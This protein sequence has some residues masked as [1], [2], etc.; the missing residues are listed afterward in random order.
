MNTAWTPNRYRWTLQDTP[1]AAETI[2]SAG[3]KY[4]RLAATILA[5]RD[6]ATADEADAFLT[7]TLNGLHDPAALYGCEQAGVILADA[8]RAEK[9]IV[10]YGDYDVD[11][12]TS[13]SILVSCIEMLGGSARYY[14]PHRLDEGYGLNAEAVD[15]LIGQGAEMIVTVDCGVTAV[16]T[17]ASVSGRGCEFIITDHHTPSDTLP[18]VAAIVHPA[19]GDAPVNPNLCGAG[20]AFKLAWQTARAM[21][22]NTRVDDEMRT[23]LLEATTLAALGTIADVVPLTG[24]NRLLASFGLRGLANC[25][26]PGVAALVKLARLEGKAITA[27]DVAFSI[28][29]RINAAGRMGHADEAVDLLATTD[30]AKAAAMASAIDKQNLRRREVEKEITAEAIAMVE[31]RGLN[32]DENRSI[33][34]A[35]EHWHGGVIGIVASRL[36]D[37]YHRP[38]VLIGTNSSGIGQ[39]SG[40]SVRGFNLV[41]ALR[42]CDE[43]LL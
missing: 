39:G 24:E 17:L 34:L 35:S 19:L 32:Q 33:V 29:P 30:P 3:K 1:A 21:C 7:P 31:E 43:N 25:Q 22:G 26:R 38:T 8:I 13:V 20:V 12:I 10:I 36:V 41:D 37:R 27:R 23:F 16:E 6:V 4:S 5:L 42:A 2:A 14:I 11:G 9:S 18:D 28:A 15:D 40:R